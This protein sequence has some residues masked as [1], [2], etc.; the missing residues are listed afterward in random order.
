MQ[1]MV[2]SSAYISRWLTLVVLYPMAVPLDASP[3]HPYLIQH[4]R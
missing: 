4:M 1:C 2:V 3:R